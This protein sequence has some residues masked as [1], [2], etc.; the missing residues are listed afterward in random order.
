MPTSTVARLLLDRGIGIV[1]SGG[2]ARGIAGIGVLRALLELGVPIDAVGGTSIGSLIA[3]GAA[4]G[5][6]PDEIANQLRRAVLDTSPFDV[7]FPAVSLASGKRVTQRLQEA[8]E[9]LDVEDG[10]RQFFCVSTNLTRGD[11]EIHRRGPGWYAVRASFSIPGV[12]PPVRTPD[13]DLL[14]DGG[15]LDNLPVGVMRGEHAGITVIAVDVGRTRDLTAGMLPADGVVS[16]WRLLLSRIDPGT[17]NQADSAGLFRIL[18]RL[19]ELGSARTDDHGDVYVRPAVDAFSIAD[20]KAFDR[21]IDLGYEA[22]MQTVG[23]WLASEDTP[24]F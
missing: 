20:F 10:W 17:P 13:S 5:Q 6:T 15:V 3:G 23:D 2:G 14:V 7:T 21:L 1:F 11:I 19:T 22:G 12:F 16:G 9:G 18:M 24:K 8:A 4:R